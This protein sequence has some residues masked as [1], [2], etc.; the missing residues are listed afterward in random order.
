MRN[1]NH[2]NPLRIVEVRRILVQKR[3]N[4]LAPT[5]LKWF[6]DIIKRTKKIC[7]Y[8]VFH[9]RIEGGG[10]LE[11]ILLDHTET[12][13]WCRLVQ[14]NM[15][16]RYRTS[17]ATWIWKQV[18]R[19]TVCPRSSDPFYIVNYYITL[20]LGHIADHRK[21]CIYWIGC[22]FMVARKNAHIDSNNF[23]FFQSGSYQ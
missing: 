7:T 6:L 3:S 19:L 21:T 9:R 22:S 17:G 2:E 23:F 14:L 15:R 16:W 20:L 10:W 4:S 12:L 18:N 8:R 13:N 1:L 11:I 5:L